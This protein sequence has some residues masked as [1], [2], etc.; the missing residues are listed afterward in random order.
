MG[1]LDLLCFN[2]KFRNLDPYGL[3]ERIGRRLYGAT[4]LLAPHPH[5]PKK[6]PA[7]TR[8]SSGWGLVGFRVQSRNKDSRCLESLHRACGGTTVTMYLGTGGTR[9]C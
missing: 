4:S 2:L 5:P 6:A 1:I 8:K 9:V 7:L 3:R